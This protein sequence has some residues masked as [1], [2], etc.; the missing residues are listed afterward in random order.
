MPKEAIIIIIIAVIALVIIWA[1]T[2][3]T[4]AR[5]FTSKA[6]K[7]D[8]IKKLMNGVPYSKDR[9]KIMQ[10]LCLPL[11]NKDL[12]GKKLNRQIID[13]LAQYRSIDFAADAMMQAS[14]SS[15]LIKNFKDDY[16]GKILKTGYQDP[17]DKVM[18]EK[19]CGPLKVEDFTKKK[20]GK[21]EAYHL[22]KTVSPAFAAD[23]VMQAPNSASLMKII[24]DDIKPEGNSSAYEPAEKILKA[25]YQKGHYTKEIGAKDGMVLSSA[26]N[27]WNDCGWHNDHPAIYFKL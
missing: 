13:Y 20:L 7:E 4:R 5:L 10:K 3:K 15:A 8:S 21:E 22:V 12:A 1:A 9:D 11:T 26:V 18:F 17:A 23:V 19:I 27:E 14:N 6:K 16:L 25:A 24:L 2:G